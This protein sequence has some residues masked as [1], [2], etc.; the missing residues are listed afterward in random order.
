MFAHQNKLASFIIDDSFCKPDYETEDETIV[1]A[2]AEPVAAEPEAAESNTIIDMI[3]ENFPYQFE[4]EYYPNG[5]IKSQK[6]I[7]TSTGI[8]CGIFKEYYSDGTIHRE[9]YLDNDLLQNCVK[10]Y[11]PGGSGS[12]LQYQEYDDGY[13]NGDSIT[14][15]QS[16][17]IASH[18]KYRLL[19]GTR[20]Y[21]TKDFI[22]LIDGDY[23][24]YFENSSPKTHIIYDKGKIKKIVYAT[25]TSYIIPESNYTIVI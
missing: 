5:K 18:K 15:Y 3:V 1:P 7:N 23:Y 17:T 14:Y 12:L 21:V 24:E 2:A 6:T 25:K 11:Y 10:T 13:L 8:G 4:T 16:G 19:L 9:G 22:S 20:D